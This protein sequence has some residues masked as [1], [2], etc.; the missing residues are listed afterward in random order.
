MAYNEKEEIIEIYFSGAYDPA[1]M[2]KLAPVLAKLI[3]EK[4]CHKLLLDYRQKNGKLNLSTL[5]LYKTPQKVDQ[6]YTKQGVDAV[7]LK[8]AILIFEQD[9]DIEFLETVNFNQGHFLKVFY[10]ETSAR[11]WLCKT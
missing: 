7:Q 5:N 10:D 6:E 1:I 2:E 9:D 11:E 3:D 4:Q 8:R